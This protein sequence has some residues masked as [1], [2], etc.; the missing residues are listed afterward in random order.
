MPGIAT[1]QSLRAYTD[2]LEKFGKLPDED[3]LVYNTEERMSGNGSLMRLCPVPLLY[4]Q[5]TPS[6]VAAMAR[7]SS[8]PTHASP[9]CT[10]ACA[11]FALYIYHLV[12]SDLPT[13]AERKHAVLDPDF[14]VLEGADKSVLAH[15]TIE[16]IRRGGGWR[17]LPRDQIKTTGFVISTLQ[18]ALWALDTFNTFEEG[19]MALLTMGADVDTVRWTCLKGGLIPSRW[20]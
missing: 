20:S 2:Y 5:S 13:P 6:E 17:G 14:D 15:P 9:L 4:T 18:A 3:E 12:R 1:S 8:L 10:G 7:A 19:M 11:L 16:S